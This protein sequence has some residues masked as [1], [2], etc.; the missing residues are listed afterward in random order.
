[1]GFFMQTPAR[2]RDDLLA[3][4]YLMFSC[5]FDAFQNGVWV[6]CGI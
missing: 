2:K 1:M 5:V 4:L 6:R 3:L